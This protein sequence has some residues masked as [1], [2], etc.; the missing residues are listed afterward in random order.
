MCRKS[1]GSKS[2]AAPVDDQPLFRRS[3]Y[4]AQ[5]LVKGDF[6]N[7]VRLPK[8]VELP[9]WLASNTFDFFKLVNMFYDVVSHDCTVAKCPVMGAGPVHE[10][11]WSDLQR[12]TVRLSGPQ[13][14]DYVLS[15]V[16]S[17]LNDQRIFPTK[18]AVPFTSD[19]GQTL[20][21]I[22]LQ[23]FRVLAHLFWSHYKVLVDLR[24]EAHLNSVFAHF[25]CFCSEFELLDRKDIV[26]MHD[27]L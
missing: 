12:K 20:R 4:K 11:H 27:Y 24:L 10:F 3:E 18:V 15:Q 23:L 13:Y 26:C 19:F 6:S 2:R 8:Y 1:L 17:I 16:Q 5:Q 9:E 25:M 22:Y 7:V 21:V 14:V